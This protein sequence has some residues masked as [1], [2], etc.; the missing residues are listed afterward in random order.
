M[1]FLLAFLNRRFCATKFVMNGPGIT[2]ALPPI[3]PSSTSA[4]SASVLTTKPSLA[5]SASFQ[6]QL[7][8]RTQLP[9]RRTQLPRPNYKSIPGFFLPSLH[10]D[11]QLI[12]IPSSSPFPP[13]VLAQ[14]AFN[15]SPLS[16]S[17]FFRPQR[18]HASPSGP[19]EPQ[20]SRMAPPSSR[21]SR[22]VFVRLP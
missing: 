2:T 3:A 16:A 10:I 5:P 22:Q 12:S 4:S 18:L 13:E 7:S 20:H 21:L 17:D 15:C 11:H 1:Q 9:R 19:L 6:Y 8:A 14:L